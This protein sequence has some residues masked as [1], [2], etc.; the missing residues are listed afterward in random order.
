MNSVTRLQLPQPPAR[1]IAPAAQSDLAS[2]SKTHA[3]REMRSGLRIV[4]AGALLVG[5]WGGSRAA[6]RGRHT[7]GFGMSESH[8]KKVQHPTGGVMSRINVRDGDKIEA[9][10]SLIRLDDTAAKANL[11]VVIGQLDAMRAR[12]ARL[13]AERDG[14][15][16][17]SAIEAWRRRGQAAIL[18]AEKNL[19]NARK[20]S[21]IGQKE[22]L[23]GRIGQL[24]EELRGLD[25][26]MQSQTAQ[27]DL[28]DTEMKG[29]CHPLSETARAAGAAHR[30]A[31]R[32]GGLDGVQGQLVSSCG[33]DARQGRRGA[34]AGRPARADFSAEVMKDLRETQDKVAELA[35]RAVA[36][37]D[38][39]AR[40]DIHTQASGVVHQLAVH[41]L[42]GVAGRP[43]RS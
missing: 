41:T 5:G 26:Q 24:E 1:R 22:L 23:V 29:V 8:V 35:E 11:Q 43:A 14:K 32:G 33:G 18:A 20:T 40:I 17:A 21:R 4:V 15:E 39:F 10:A 31:T 37:R 3:A 30:P 13:V 16:M 7:R 2:G 27:R 19:F 9:G 12:A 28:I 36:A 34:A 25:A 38:L 6:L 42:G